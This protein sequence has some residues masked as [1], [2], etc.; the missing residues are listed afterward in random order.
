MHLSV[1][2][3]PA[4]SND[5]IP[6]PTPAQCE[7]IFPFVYVTLWE[8][9]PHSGEAARHVVQE[10]WWYSHGSPSPTQTSLQSFRVAPA[11]IRATH[12]SVVKSHRYEGTHVCRHTSILAEPGV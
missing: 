11:P 1:E 4:Q 6:G 8:H 3:S 5:R 9:H 12:L 10:E 7:P 2:Y